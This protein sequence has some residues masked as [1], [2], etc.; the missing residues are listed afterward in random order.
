MTKLPKCTKCGSEFTYEDGALYVCPDCFHEWTKEEEESNGEQD[1]VVRDVHGNEL[2]SGDSV[3][4]IRDLK[5]K[6]A[7]SDIKVGTKVKDIRIVD[8][9]NG[10]DIEAKIKGFGAVMLKSSVVKKSN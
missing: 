5:L 4:V 10:H 3:T 2:K 8:P 6:G 9:V 1:Q 7:S